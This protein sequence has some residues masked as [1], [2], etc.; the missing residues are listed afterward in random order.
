MVIGIPKE[1]KVN[2]YRVASVPADVKALTAKG[3]T[4]YVEHDAGEGSGFSDAMYQA[5]GA[6]IGTKEEVF[7]KSDLIYKVKEMDPVE[8]DLLREGQIIITYLHSNSHIAMARELLKRKVIAIAYEDVVDENGGF[9]LLAPMSVLAGKGGFIASLYYMQAVHGGK[10][11]LMSRTPGIRT[12]HVTIIGCGHA[13]MGAAELAA[14]FG[15]KVTMLDISYKAMQASKEKL[16]SNVE[17]MYSNRE[18]LVECLRQTDVVINCIMWPKTRK[19]PMISREDL[20]MMRPSA[21]IVDVACDIPGAVETCRATSHDD[22]IYYEEGIMHYCVDNIPSGFAQTASIMLSSATL[23]Y[24]R[25]IADKGLEQA[26]TDNAL[27]R[28]GLTCYYGDLT[29]EE[30][31][32]KHSIPYVDPM[33]AFAKH[34]H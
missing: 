24:V 13:G 21:M 32:I 1:V 9:P 17:F 19:D 12:P 4:V 3:H 25:S 15:C 20:H 34:Q 5:A 30:T 33:D 10:G 2:E 8:Y 29:L 28:R 6:V 14:A 16:P 22:P 11:V 7:K 26:L 31:A 18:N 23:P 27:L